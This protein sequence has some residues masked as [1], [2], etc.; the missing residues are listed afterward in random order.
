MTADV[1]VREEAKGADRQQPPDRV[2][3]FDLPDWVPGWAR[4]APKISVTPPGPRSREIVKMDKEYVSHAYDRVF[5]FTIERAAGA[6]VADVDGNVYI[7]WTSG[8]AVMNAGWGHPGVVEAIKS[9]SEK[10]IHSFANDIYF[11]KEAELAKILS[12]ISFSGKLRGTFFG[13]SG[14]EAV[15]AAAKLASYSTKKFEFLSFYGAYHGRVGNAL[16]FTSKLKYR[17]GYGPLNN[18]IF[19]PYAYCYRCPFKMEYPSCDLYCMHFMEE[20]VMNLGG[21]TGSLAAVVVEPVQGEGGYIVPPDTFMPFLRKFCDKNG[22]LLIADEVQS[23]LGRTGRIWASEWTNTMP[24]ILVAGKAVGGGIPLGAIIARPEIMKKWRPGAHSSTFGGN[25]I[26]MAAGIAHINAI[27]TERLPERAIGAGEYIMKRLREMQERW[28]IIGDV[29]GRGLMIGVEFVK[30]RKTKEPLDLT[31]MQVK[32]FKKG[33]L[34]L[35]AGTY[36]NVMRIAPPLIISTEFIDR[37]LEIFESV[38]KEIQTEL[39]NPPAAAAPAAPGQASGDLQ[40]PA[41]S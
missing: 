2:V 29:R 24:D 34:T 28:D 35:T 11:D 27:L 25:A 22:A 17:F 4:D 21:G 12:D 7:D 41:T 3:R 26:Q 14:A 36:G 6:A 1:N 8:I 37:G 16:N 33:L 19:A 18:T 30:D 15:G 31:Q 38:V 10:L 32:C 39:R 5:T 9:Q 40:Q 23:G 13:N 20:Q